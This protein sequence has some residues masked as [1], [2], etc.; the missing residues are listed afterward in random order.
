[1][2]RWEKQ[3]ATSKLLAKT[4]GDAMPGYSPLEGERSGMFSKDE[5][6]ARTLNT[7]CP[8]MNHSRSEVVAIKQLKTSG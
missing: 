5:N 6:I 4:I 3:T 2:K 8:H 7:E 1:V